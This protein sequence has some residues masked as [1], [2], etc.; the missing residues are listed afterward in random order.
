MVLCLRAVGGVSK[1]VSP[2]GTS[3]HSWPRNI[4]EH[5]AQ[6]VR[7]WCA[8]MN[9]FAIAYGDRFTRPGM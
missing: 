9:Q 7:E 4:T 3:L 6:A 2:L 1:G 5:R 8:A